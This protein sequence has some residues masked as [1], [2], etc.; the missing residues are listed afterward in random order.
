MV[1]ER[2]TFLA[3]GRSGDTWRERAPSQIPDANPARP[4]DLPGPKSARRAGREETKRT[5]VGERLH[6]II[7]FL[8]HL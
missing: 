1:M 4:P 6:I 2:W 7:D 3:A 5:R 8:P